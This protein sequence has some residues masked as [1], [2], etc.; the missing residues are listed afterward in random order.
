[1]FEEA[2]LYTPVT[3]SPDGGVTV[4]LAADHPGAVDPA[5]RARRNAL[6]ALAL[7]WQPGMPP[8]TAPYTDAEHDVWRTV[9]RELH[10]LHETLACAAYQEGKDRLGLPESRIPQ[11]AEV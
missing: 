7:E 9:C 8:P 11:L 4:H 2:Q 3:R 10:V 6:A 1:M 5:Y